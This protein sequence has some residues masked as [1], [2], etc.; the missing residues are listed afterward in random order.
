ML[1]ATAARFDPAVLEILRDT[2]KL[3]PKCEREMVL[4]TAGR[5]TGAGEKFWGGFGVSPMPLYD[6]GIE[7]PVQ[8][9]ACRRALDSAVARSPAWLTPASRG[10]RSWWCSSARGRRWGWR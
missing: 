4:R 9:N 8:G 7:R 3:C 1:E 5:G 10:A 2:R 6:A